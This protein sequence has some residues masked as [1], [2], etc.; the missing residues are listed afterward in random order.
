ME[1]QDN[2]K[3]GKKWGGIVIAFILFS[4]FKN[5]KIDGHHLFTGIFLIISLFFVPWLYYKAKAKIKFIKDGLIKDIII[6]AIITVSSI[7]LIGIFG[8]LGDR[9]ILKA[10]SDALI[11]DMDTLTQL[12]NDQKTYFADFQNKWQE[13]ENKVNVNPASKWDC[14]GNIY[15]YED[16]RRLN[17]EQ[18]YK[19]EEFFNQSLSILSKYFN[20]LENAS[21]LGNALS[22]SADIARKR[23]GINDKI[24]TAKIN[25]YQALIDH[26]S[27]V[28]VETKRLIIEGLIDESNGLDTEAI[29]AQNNLQ[30]E[31]SK[32]FN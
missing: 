4:S 10:P 22:R 20:K 6:G 13:S 7:F 1:N 18:K 8:A 25:Y 12:T 15:I 32:V 11:K 9:L 31:Y 21:S 16:L 30:L 23:N 19:Q 17:S 26:E 24:F 27:E 14:L 29:Q 2:A 28:T 3:K 5:L